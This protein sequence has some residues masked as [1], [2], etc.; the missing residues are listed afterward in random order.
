MDKNIDN[1]QK[2]I[3]TGYQLFG[4]MGPVA[5]NV[6][7][8]SN[9]IGLNRSSFYHYF[10]DMEVFESQLL[11]YHISRYA[12]FYDLIKDYDQFDMLFEDEVM[13]HKDELAFQRQLLIHESVA[14][15]KS[16][17]DEARKHTEAKTYELWSAF[18]QQSNDSTE[19]WTLFRAVRDFYYIHHGQVKDG[20]VES[21]P[22]DVL[23]L[24][25]SYMNSKS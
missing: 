25:H 22:R 4:E 10:G 14:R 12:F 2:W 8:L 7:K 18:N 13:Q 5:L 3:L 23:V 1:R 15:Y 19:S 20:S 9:I 17:S 11:T 21:N 16:C 6:E 24:L